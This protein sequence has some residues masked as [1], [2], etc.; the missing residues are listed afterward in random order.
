MLYYLALGDSIT[1]GYGVGLNRSFASLLY[2]SLHVYYPGLIYRNFGLDGCTTQHLHV[3][4]NHPQLQYCLQNSALITMTI[5]SNDLIES[6]PL[7]I[8]NPKDGNKVLTNINAHLKNIGKQIRSVNHLCRI[9]IAAIYNPLPVSQYAA[10]SNFGESLIDELN[11]RIIYWAKHNK[12]EYIPV[13]QI[14]RGREA[15]VLTPDGIHPNMYGHSLI[16]RAFSLNL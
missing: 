1:T 7:L 12:A 10:Y 5:G 8:N 9:K 11:N 13:D 6:I 2:R 14:F 3:R 16:A 15:S 4:L